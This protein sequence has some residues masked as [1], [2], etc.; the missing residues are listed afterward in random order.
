MA[1][2]PEA[3]RRGDAGL[4]V[5][6]LHERLADLGLAT[7]DAPDQFGDG[8]LAV[9]EAF[10]RSRGLAITGV[11]DATTRARLV[12]AGYRL[13]QRLLFET[14]PH[15]RGDDVADLQTRLAQLGF[16][17]GRID[18]IFGPLL[19]RALREFQRNRGLAVDGT[20]TRATLVDLARVAA[21]AGDRHLITEVRD[22]AGVDEPTSKVVVLCGSSPLR[23]LVAAAL[24][25]ATDARTVTGTP[26]ECAAAANELDAALVLSLASREELDGL[27]LHYWASYRAHSRRGERLA[28]AIAGE[29]A[30]AETL[31]RVEVTGMA[32]PILRETRMTTLHVEHGTGTPD[33]LAAVARDV[34]TV[35]GR[36]I[37]RFDESAPGKAT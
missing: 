25:P 27:H 6:E 30:R 5:R 7:T 28:G 13:G 9:V 35:V 23:D 4:A 3:L 20:L 31:W 26:E 17:P 22:R 37:H 10:Q 18:G 12:E 11:V 33:V 15:L 1:S 24:A 36:F 19:D 29:L 34:A 21:M 8:T 14:Q 32:L 16:D 2:D